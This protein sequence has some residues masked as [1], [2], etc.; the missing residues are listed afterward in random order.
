MGGVGRYRGTSDSAERRFQLRDDWYPKFGYE[1]G[2]RVPIVGRWGAE[3]RHRGLQEYAF[4]EPHHPFSR[5]QLLIG[6]VVR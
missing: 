4:T 3:A 5:S 6:V 1:L 2:I